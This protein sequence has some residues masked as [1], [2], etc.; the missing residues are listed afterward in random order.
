MNLCVTM[1]VQVSREQAKVLAAKA[2]S[3]SERD[4]ECQQNE[5]GTKCAPHDEPSELSWKE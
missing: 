1:L 2:L 5:N 4:W 3:S